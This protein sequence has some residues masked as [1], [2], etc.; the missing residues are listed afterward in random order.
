MIICAKLALF[1]L[2]DHRI[3]QIEVNIVKSE[4]KPNM[5]NKRTISKIVHD[6]FTTIEAPQ[7]IIS[8]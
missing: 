2:G 4:C 1:E 3:L 7:T 6:T 5:L 8:V